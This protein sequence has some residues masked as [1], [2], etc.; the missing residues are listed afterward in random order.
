M[1]LIACHECDLLQRESDVQ[2]AGRV[3]CSRC[4]SLLYRNVPGS[5][6]RSLALTIAAAITFVIAN[7]FPFVTI[8]AAGRFV[9]STILGSILE[10]WKQGMLLVAPLVF[11]NAVAIPGMSILATGYVLVR[12]KFGK[13][14]RHLI[15]VLRLL[16]KVKPWGMVEV[17]LL[18]LL[19]SVV[20]LGAYARVIPD[21]ALWAIG[22][23]VLFT[24][25]ISTVFDPRVIW[26]QIEVD[27]LNR[28][29]VLGGHTKTN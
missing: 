24:A 6:D 1:G 22:V 7:V 5:V 28:E 26:K 3:V 19:V 23:L 17:F 18:G 14:P 25:A 27:R 9:Q 13:T 11:L 29:P 15:E 2:V 10:M 4:G 16:R 8:S 21:T 20:K 12:T